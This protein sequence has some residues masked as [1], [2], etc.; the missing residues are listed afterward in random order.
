MKSIRKAKNGLKL[1][2]KQDQQRLVVV[3]GIM[4][5]FNSRWYP[6]WK[7]W[8]GRVIYTYPISWSIEYGVIV[9]T[10]RRY[11]DPYKV[12]AKL[13]LLIIA[14]WIDMKTFAVDQLVIFGSPRMCPGKAVQSSEYVLDYHER[15]EDMYA[16]A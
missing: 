15:W 9:G 1:V 4:N 12:F 14:N 16:N 13:W 8:R 6:S 2:K 7:C 5:E 10:G 11:E 3:L